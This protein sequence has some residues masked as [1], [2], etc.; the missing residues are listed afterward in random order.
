MKKI[1]LYIPLLFCFVSS[2]SQNLNP[3]VKHAIDSLTT[4]VNNSA[5]NDSL[6]GE[7]LLALAKIQFFKAR[8]LA[9]ASE[10]VF[11]A[12]ELAE[13][14]DYK[15]LE[16]RCNDL[17]GWM[18]DRKENVFKAVEYMR[19]ASNY[20]KTTDSDRYHFL[21]AYNLGCMLSNAEKNKEAKAHLS[22]AVELARKTKNKSWLLNSLKALA[23]IHRKQ[24]KIDEAIS[25]V[26]ESAKLVQE[27]KGTYGNGR[28]PYTLA[29]L[30]AEK[31]DYS[32]ANKWL[33]EA[34]ICAKRGGDMLLFKEVYFADFQI[35]K[36][37]GNTVRALESYEKYI[38]Y[39]D[40]I[41]NDDA[42]NQAND[43]ESKYLSDVK[44]LEVEKAEAEKKLITSEKKR[45]EQQRN[46]LIGGVIFVLIALGIVAQRF[47]L[48]R[49]QKGVIEKQ[50]ALVDEKNKEILDSIS[51]AK[52]IQTA[53]LPPSKLVKQYLKDSF[54]LYKPK[55]IVAGDFYWLAHKEDKVLFA[56][57]DCTG[58]GVPGAMVSVVCNNG[59][60]RSVKEYNLTD[61][62]K[63]LDKTREI[64]IQEFEKSEEDVK[65]G[66]DIALCSL[67]ADTLQY[68]GAHNPLWI[69]RN[70]SDVIE[71]I[72]AN[73]QPIGK[74]DV[75]QPF[76]THEIKVNKGDTIYIFSDGYA[77]QFGGDKGKKM[78]TSNLKKLLLSVKHE[79][80][81]Q[82]QILLEKAFDEW[83]G[84]LEQLD[85]VCLIG[86]KV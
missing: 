74:V 19:K 28:I 10:N 49:K 85:D 84:A 7:S 45:S 36:K 27:L 69:I 62:G 61:P 63:I 15:L 68:A 18:E 35:Q 64:V 34:F 11:E 70:D 8:D 37:Q 26:Q 12:L 86:V 46:W 80:M 73:K 20:Y 72:K 53:I 81:E 24:G 50:K 2:Y 1:A 47:V 78:K 55:D 23:D 30:Y 58:H 3:D 59:L 25:L 4:R 71:E 14:K 76:T 52:R 42:L 33:D 29:E 9:S 31:E 39:K 22:D 13:R 16:A 57:A 5:L 38:Q 6:R 54:I 44:R 32:N 43:A 48:T 56:A 66:M 67:E 21:A 77:D 51:Y 60:N 83:R 79:S 75:A 17:L 40:S 41:F 65:D 82:Q